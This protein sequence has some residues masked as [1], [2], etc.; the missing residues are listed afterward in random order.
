M[1]LLTAQSHVSTSLMGLTGVVRRALRTRP[2]LAL[3]PSLLLVVLVLSSCKFETDTS[4]REMVQLTTAEDLNRS[5]RDFDLDLLTQSL[6]DIK[7]WHVEN[8]TGLAEELRPGLSVETISQ[9]FSA[10]ATDC[11]PTDELIALWSWHDGAVSAVPAIWYH[12][13]LPLDQALTELDILL[14]D[15]HLT[16]DPH[17]IPVFSFD[18]EWYAAYCGPEP[19]TSGPIVHFFIEQ[20]PIITHVNLTTFLAARAEAFRSRVVR[21]EDAAMVENVREL[22]RIHERFNEGY[23]FPYALPP[24]QSP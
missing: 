18:G 10:A 3:A 9:A 13:F 1:S 15:D 11:V 12:D 4:Q 7:A 19:R 5:L 21:W 8:A 22:S 23:P 14:R 16:W 24:P 2:R 6:E 20:D 17:Y